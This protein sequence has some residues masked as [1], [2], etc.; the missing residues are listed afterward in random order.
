VFNKNQWNK[1]L[2]ALKN[3]DYSTIIMA[4]LYG[5]TRFLG[6]FSAVPTII[7]LWVLKPFVWIKVGSL[8]HGRIGHLAMNTDLFLRR[9][10]LSIYPGRPFYCFISNP[11]GLAN[12]QLLNMWKR[13]IPVYESRVLSWLYYGMLPILKRTPFYQDLPFNANEYYEFNNTNSALYFTDDEI[14]KGRKLLNQMN[15]DLDKDEFVCIFARSDAYL[16]QTIPHINFGYHDTRCSDIDSLIEATKYLIEKGFKVIRIGSIVNKPINFSHE[17]LTDYP[18]SKNQSD[19]LDIFLLAYCKLV[20]SA[21][22]SGITDVATLFDCPILAVNV[23]ENWYAPLLKNSLYTPKKYKY[24]NTNNYLRFQEGIKLGAFWKDLK[25]HGLETEEASPQ[26]I[27]EATE[28]MMARLEGEFKYSP[29]SE[30]LIQ[31]YQKVWREAGVIGHKTQTPVGIAWLK[32][33]QALYF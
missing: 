27:L 2:L 15:V 9:R 8:Q 23:A 12:R 33:N 26:E 29:E 10:Q 5:I 7:I 14:E 4:F 13:V 18:Y 19:F 17:K 21:G 3:R 22:P 16:K 30:R 6:L 28:E 24:C 11:N 20:I 25:T 1:F 32:K 31:A